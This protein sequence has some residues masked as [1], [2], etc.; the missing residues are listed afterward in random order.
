MPF[1]LFFL[2]AL[3]LLSRALPAA[4]PN[5]ILILCDDLGY[6]DPRC[7]NPQSK[8]PTPHIDKLAAEG[9]R[10][11]D[12][13]TPSSVC[14]PTRYGLL[15]GRYCWRT[16]LKSSVLDGFDPPLIDEGRLTLASM[17]KS[18]GYATGMVGK[19]H[20]GMEWI[21]RDGN[22]MPYAVGARRGFRSGDEVDYTRKISAGPVDRG[23]DWYYGISASLDMPPYCL[24]ENRNVLALPTQTMPQSRQLALSVSQGARSDG[25]ELDAVLPAF[26][27]KAV[28]FI[29]SKAKSNTPL[30]LYLP[31]NS[32]HLPVVPG[33]EWR[34]K[35]GA[36]DYA[37]FTAQTDA[38]VGAVMASLDAAG[39][40]DN[41][42]IL[43]TSDNGGL[44]HAWQAREADDLAAYKPTPR[45][46]YNAGHG[47][48]SNAHLRG[49][50]AD[51]WEGGHRVPFI[52]RW[53]AKVAPGV[54]SAALVELTDVI[55]TLAQIVDFKLPADA[56]EDSFSFLPV[57]LDAKG[58]GAARPFSVH[59]SINGS[60]ALRQGDWKFTPVRGSAGF[61]VPKII[62]PKPGE[63]AGQLYNLAEDPRE[64]N[65]LFLAHP[66]IV[67]MMSKQLQS[68]QSGDRTAPAPAPAPAK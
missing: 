32:P 7:Y 45:G 2:S 60:F 52:I 16:R 43:F 44:W 8:I 21:T 48:H 31:L 40:A 17:L 65:N 4:P 26:T 30:F 34:G 15:T 53:P 39:I 58:R 55:A 28:E 23:F 64:T 37:D 66:Q 27:Q 13:H 9:M 14:T 1:R 35:T 63:P 24:I 42:L 54:V 19:W 57:L 20:L 3:L 33:K 51:I 49:A 10:F 61:T 67:Q 6:G 25:F 41:T 68:I 46:A 18:R 11:T 59:H 36:G 12:A 62:Q 5:I 56:A 29:E 47:H 50:K 22:A 38:T